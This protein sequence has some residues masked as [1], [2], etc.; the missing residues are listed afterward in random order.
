MTFDELQNIAWAA[1]LFEGE[2]CASFRSSHRTKRSFDLAL[3]S[4]DED[5]VRRFL[6][7]VKHGTIYGPKWGRRSTKPYWVWNTTRR[8]PFQCRRVAQDV[9]TAIRRMSG[10]G[11]KQLDIARQF[12]ISPS[13]VSKIVSGQRR[14]GLAA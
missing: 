10:T 9:V 2:G 7:T 4:T 5:V 14:G 8:R 6:A 13:A 12:K 11:M 1:G 3:A